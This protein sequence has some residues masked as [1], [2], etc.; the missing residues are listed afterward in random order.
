MLEATSAA[1]EFKDYVTINVISSPRR[2]SIGDLERRV[3]PIC[4]GRLPP[5]ASGAP[6]LVRRRAYSM[7]MMLRELGPGRSHSFWATDVD[8][9]IWDRA[10]AGRGYLAS[11]CATWARAR[12]T[13]VTAESG[14]KYAVGA[15]LRP[16]V[17]WET[18][19]L[20]GS[21]SRAVRHDRVQQSGDLL[22]ED[23]KEPSTRVS[24]APY[25]RR[26]LFVGARSHHARRRRRL[27]SNGAGF[28]SQGANR[29]EHRAD[30]GP[31]PE[32]PEQWWRQPLS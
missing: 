21:L 27:V 16:M 13:L 8:P 29:N 10:K 1:Q 12:G 9:T 32:S 18:H 4:S 2:R 28:L 11:D 22:T 23:A 26:C 25:D 14:G 7:A 15:A 6:M 17:R 5:C 31:T 3:L 30:E 19:D 20:C 24:S